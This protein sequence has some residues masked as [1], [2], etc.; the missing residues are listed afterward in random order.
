[1]FGKLVY[2]DKKAV[3]EYKSIIS[4]KPNLEIE[5]YDVTNDKGINAD[6]RLVSAD[7]KASKS[8]TAKVQESSLF[9]C[10]QFEKMLA[11]RDDFF[12]FTTSSDYDILTV[13]NRSIIKMDGYIEV[14]EDFDMVKVIEAFKPYLMQSDQIQWMEEKSKM[15][16]QTFLGSASATKIPLVFEG[17]DTLFCSKILQDNVVVS[18]EELSE[19]EEDVNILARVTSSFISNKKAYYDPL[20]DFMMLNRMMRKSMGDRG[21]EFSPIFADDDYRMIEMLAIYR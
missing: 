1:M 16:L 2:Y 10:D 7:V 20:K 11:G 12:D 3:S 17:E 18:Y 9:D 4:G 21:K 8:Y 13:P 14:P 15:A 19:I 5:S 6:L